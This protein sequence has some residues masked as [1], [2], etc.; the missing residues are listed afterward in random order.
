MIS[1]DRD[2]VDPLTLVP[3]DKALYKI[4][5]VEYRANAEA[6]RLSKEKTADTLILTYAGPGGIQIEKRLTFHND[7]YKIDIVVN[8]KALDGYRIFLGTDFGI[9][10]KLSSDASGRVGL[11]ALVDGKV[12]TDKLDKIKGEAQYTGTIGWFGHEDKYFTATM[13]NG[14][15]GILTSTKTPGDSENGRASYNESGGKRKNGFAHLCALRR[16][17]KLY[18]P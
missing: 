9:A 10:D 15:P 13:V 14:T 11:A 3:L 8:T 1:I 18:A 2:I 17:E 5:G 16:T 7:N 4:S 6:I 12:T